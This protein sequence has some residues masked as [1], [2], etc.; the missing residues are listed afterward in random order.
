MRCYGQ[1]FHYT[2]KHPLDR[3]ARI[4]TI[5]FL[6]E[7]LFQRT[8]KARKMLDGVWLSESLC[9]KLEFY[10]TGVALHWK[11]LLFHKQFEGWLILHLYVPV[12]SYYDMWFIKHKFFSFCLFVC[13]SIH[14]SVVHN[15]WCYDQAYHWPIQT[16]NIIDLWYICKKWNQY[17]MW[18]HAWW[19]GCSW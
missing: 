7:I 5:V 4:F 6:A 18:I 14:C 19:F 12:Y 8:E 9:L 16:M 2:V 11:F 3:L 17:I 13:N 15:C 1:W 10:F